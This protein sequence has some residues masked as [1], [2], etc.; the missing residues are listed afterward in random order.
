MNCN[1]NIDIPTPQTE[2]CGGVYTS[3]QC[4]VHA[5]AII[6]LSLPIN[7]SINTIINNMVLALM[8]KDEQIASLIARIEILETP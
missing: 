1:N 6:Y 8:Y 4:I 5:D 3:D 2:V 7:S